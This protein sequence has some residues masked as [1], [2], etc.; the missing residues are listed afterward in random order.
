L[1]DDCLALY[2]LKSWSLLNLRSVMLLQEGSDRDRGHQN[3]QEA[4]LLSKPAVTQGAP[5]QSLSTENKGGF[6]CIPF[7]A[8][9]R[10]GG[11]ADPIHHH[12]L[13]HWLF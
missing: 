4:S 9:Y 8:D 7:R 11:R 1:K 6:P 12:M 5:V 3:F 10:N 13:F 2:H